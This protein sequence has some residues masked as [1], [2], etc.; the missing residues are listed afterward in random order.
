MNE[1]LMKINKTFYLSG[2][3]M[4]LTP[5]ERN[6]W[7]VELQKMFSEIYHVNLFNPCDHWDFNSPY[8]D[9]KEAM[10]YDLH[11]LR[12]S[13][14]VIVNFNDIESLGTMAELAIAYELRIPIIG[15]QT[16]GDNFDLH[17]WQVFMCQK[18]FNNMEALF[19][20]L[21]AHYVYED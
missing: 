11:R 20:Y 15:L 8:I 3:M 9:D 2:G 7:R 18:I 5:E 16:T 4:N 1:V 10:E 19:E 6:G 14:V 12:H 13:D 17:P 21:L